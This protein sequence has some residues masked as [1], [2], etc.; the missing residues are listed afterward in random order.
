[1][2]ERVKASA[3]ARVCFGGECLD[4]M[5]NGPSVVGAIDL[6]TIALIELLPTIGDN[7][8]V[9]VKSLSPLVANTLRYWGQLHW[10][11]DQ[12]LQY[13]ESAVDMV[14]Q[15]VQNPCSLAVTIES[16]VPV[17]AGVSSSAAVVLATVQAAE[18]LFELE[19]SVTEIIETSFSVE[20]VKL[21][22][23]AGRMD[24]YASGLGGL[25]YL[26]C[27]E[28]PLRREPFNF[29]EKLGLILVDTQQPHE[30]RSFI[31]SKRQRFQNGDPDMRNYADSAEKMVER[32]RMLLPNYYDNRE[33]VGFL[34]TEFHTLLR[35]RVKCSTP[36]LE[37]CVATANVNGAL[38]AKLTGS[39]MG[40]CMFAL[41]DQERQEEV[42]LALKKL[43]VRVYSV[44]IVNQGVSIM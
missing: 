42:E 33:E 7:Y 30:T 20:N 26:N 23:G 40:G 31:S 34:M 14:R 21:M 5:I 4:W 39:G 13:V 41:V 43:P 2:I 24:F 36:M 17:K 32:M 8:I 19:Q 44:S 16:S 3:P 9:S 37:A 10:Y 27:G 18:T 35:D 6:K 29:P 15:H 38:G 22:T 28:T 12:Y 25:S 11:S 1:M